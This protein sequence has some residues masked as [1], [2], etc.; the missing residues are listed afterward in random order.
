LDDYHSCNWRKLNS[1]VS[2][3]WI[4]VWVGGRL[5]RATKGTCFIG[6]FLSGG[7][8]SLVLGNRRGSGADEEVLGFSL[9]GVRAAEID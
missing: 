4:G 6:L 2:R 8:G 1:G 3:R 5:K 7:R 9:L